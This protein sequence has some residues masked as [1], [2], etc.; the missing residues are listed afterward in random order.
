MLN[1]ALQIMADLRVHLAK[2]WWEE[3]GEERIVEHA[4]PTG[5][6]LHCLRPRK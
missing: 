6:A 1:F 5:L 3:R 2:T 4:I